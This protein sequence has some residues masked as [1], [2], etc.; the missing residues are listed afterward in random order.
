MTLKEY[1]DKARDEDGQLL[2]RFIKIIDNTERTVVFSNAADVGAT[3]NNSVEVSPST[4]K[5]IN[6][7]HDRIYTKNVKYVGC[8]VTFPEKITENSN[9]YNQDRVNTAPSGEKWQWR[10]LYIEQIIEVPEE[11]EKLLN[12]WKNDGTFN[13]NLIGK[14]GE[15]LTVVTADEYNKQMKEIEDRKRAEVASEAKRKI[16]HKKAVALARSLTEADCSVDLGWV[17]GWGYADEEEA[18]RRDA[19]LIKHDQLCHQHPEKH[20]LYETNSYRERTRGSSCIKCSGCGF[21]YSVDASD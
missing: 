1:F 10:R 9:I 15:E 14:D 2:V 7:N 5:T 6:K 16:L 18:L 3:F 17:N 21:S 11:V 19:I 20:K 12:H 13:F 8:L 4:L